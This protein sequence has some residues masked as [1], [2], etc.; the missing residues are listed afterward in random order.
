MQ[1][2]SP[3]PEDIWHMRMWHLNIADLTLLQRLSHSLSIGPPSVPTK[4]SSYVA[5]LVG[6][7]HRTISRFPRSL[8]SRAR[9]SY[10]H[11]DIC[12][13]MQSYSYIARHLYASV[14]VN[15]DS[16]FA[17]T[18]CLKTKDEL[19]D[20]LKEHI[21]RVERQTGDRVV[22]LFS[23]NEPVL[24]QGAFQTWLTSNGI[25]HYT[26]Q[27]YSPEV[28][29]IAE[30]A[31][32]QVVSRASAMLS[33][34]GI[35]IGFWPEAVRYATYLK[36]HSPHRA[37]DKTPF[38]AYF[39]SVPDLSH[40]RIFGCRCYAHMEKENRQKLDSHT[41][42]CVFI[43]YYATERLFAVF[44]VTRRVILKK[45]DVI[46]FEHVLG[47]PTMLQYGL[48]PDS[49]I[50]GLPASQDP[51][52]DTFSTATDSV[53]LLDNLPSATTH[54]PPDQHLLIATVSPVP[55]QIL[56]DTD[57]ALVTSV[58]TGDFSNDV[59]IRDMVRTHWCNYS[60]LRKLSNH[61]PTSDSS[62]LLKHFERVYVKCKERLHITDPPTD[63]TS[64][65]TESDPVSWSAAMNS[66]NKSWWLHAA[67]QEMCQ[68]AKMGTFT[69]IDHPPSN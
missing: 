31:I 22:A 19:R 54:S 41:I 63:L 35:P 60:L 50:V 32:K 65:I 5:Y 64:A 40:L 45:R 18:Y 36:N 13:L 28:N 66:P 9:H 51:L 30:N 67:Y 62:S 61:N 4:T 1:H 12:S 34:A 26:T 43:G 25:V 56:S 11:V 27:T 42:E 39:G 52:P 6:K 10:L 17:F 7:Q 38:E 53:L 23:D 46:F 49:D 58:S 44:D 15:E 8:P 59:N 69:F 20:C 3:Q 21:T 16:H 57:S 68:L 37:I 29:G 2:V 47:H 24:L 33:T 55:E 14:V 48:P